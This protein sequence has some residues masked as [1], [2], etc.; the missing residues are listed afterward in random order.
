[1]N[2]K[3]LKKLYIYPGEGLGNL[4][5]DFIERTVEEAGLGNSCFLS[6][7]FEK[8]L[9]KVNDEEGEVVLLN[10]PISKTEWFKN[11]KIEKNEGVTEFLGKFFNCNP[12]MF[13]TFLWRGKR[14]YVWLLTRHIPLKKVEIDPVNVVSRL[15]ANFVQLRKM[16]VRKVVLLG[17]NPH[18]GENGLIGDEEKNWTFLM[19]EISREYKFLGLK[20]ADTF[21]LEEDD[22]DLVISIYHDQLLPLLKFHFLDSL[23]DL[24]VGLKNRKG[25]IIW[26][27]TFPHGPAIKAIKKLTVNFAPLKAFL[28][29]YRDIN[30]I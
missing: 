14:R 30:N 19:E 13:F 6:N 9:E 3:K 2:K 16:G 18:A 4:F 15:R 7:D 11:K 27:V 21:F 26:R 5:S 1:M 24:S 12:E 10:G 17:M 20:P 28:D 8:L 23:L 29:F 25:K 22:F